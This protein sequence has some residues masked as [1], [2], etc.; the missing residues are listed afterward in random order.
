MN[1][2]IVNNCRTLIALWDTFDELHFMR[3]HNEA[4][5]EA[6]EKNIKQT[7]KLL[8]EELKEIEGELI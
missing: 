7:S 1:E 5:C 4:N 6:F 8:L 3:I 2:K